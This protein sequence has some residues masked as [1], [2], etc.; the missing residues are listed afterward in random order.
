MTSGSS[1]STWTIGRLDG[2][3]QIESLGNQAAGEDQ[4]PGGRHFAQR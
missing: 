3:A 2:T 1:E 4:H